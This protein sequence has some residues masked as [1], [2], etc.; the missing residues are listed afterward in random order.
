MGK[1][2]KN[3][4]ISVEKVKPSGAYRLSHFEDGV[5][6]SKQYMGYNKKDAIKLHKETYGK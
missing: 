3:S 5:L 2:L 6:Q 1:K 4:D